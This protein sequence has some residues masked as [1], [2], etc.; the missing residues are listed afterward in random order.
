MSAPRR[1]T[2]ERG[3]TTLPRD[4]DIF[5]PSR[6]IMPWVKSAAKG[7][8]KDEVPEVRERLDEEARVEQVQDRVL[9]AADV[10]V[11]RHPARNGVAPPR[12]LVVGGVA[13]A[14]EVPGGVDEGVHRVGLAARRPA[15][16][17]AGRGDPV[18]GGGK[19][20]APL[21][22]VVLDLG[23]QHR[24][25]ACRQRD[26]AVIG[27][28]DDGDRAAPV[29]LARD[30]P[31]AQPV[32]TVARPRRA[33][34]SHSMIARLGLA[35]GQPV[36][37]LVGVDERA[38]AAVGQ[39]AA[40][41][42]ADDA[43]HGQ[44]EGGR[45]LEVALVV[46]G[47][48]HDRAGAVL[49][50]HVVGDEH[51]DLLAV[52]RVSDGAPERHA[53]LLLAGGAPLLRG[54]E[55][56]ARHVLAHRRLVLGAGGE[57]Q[58]V[59]VLR[60][61]HEERRAEERV[62]PRR[63]DGVVGPELLAA[64]HDLGALRAPDPVALHRLDVL[65]PADRVEVRE[66]AV[67]VGGDAEEPLLELAQLDLRAAAL[68]A[69]VDD[70]LVGEHG[71]VVRA[72][73][74]GRLAAV[75]EARL[76]QLQEDPLRPAVVARLVGAEL[77]RPVEGD[78]P[79]AEVLLEGGD[80]GGGR[81]ARVHAGV[82]R[83]VLRRQ[84]EGVVADR[85]QDLQAA[86]AAE[87]RDRVADR[88]VLEVAHVRL[89]ARVGQHLEHVARRRA[90]AVGHLPGALGLPHRLPAGL[91]LARVIDALAHLGSQTSSSRSRHAGWGRARRR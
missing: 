34:S 89:A 49:H 62:G 14:Q 75:G 72:P 91:D 78:A 11:D 21:R 71:R 82:D 53:G 35:V 8:W 48:R 12:L 39:L 15:A 85:V 20:R 24:Q 27:A 88:V 67:R 26:D 31:V 2:I 70:L 55:V 66:Q 30:E 10:L 76:E 58:H 5:A 50:Q 45:E 74:D 54:L 22:R 90:A 38:L 86:A 29:A 64:E 77:P 68:A 41:G 3:E 37:A 4:F 51:R 1:S 59:G 63:E 56:R 87:V 9:D 73:V 7:S 83:M 18:L 44:A 23:E 84:P 46:G 80:R 19:R 65:G 13:V 81:V 6:V 47:H 17:R 16:D 69:A 33:S 40:R 57:P 79:A 32:V 42:V 43:A 28:V 60:R 52:D 36:E 61:H 25:L